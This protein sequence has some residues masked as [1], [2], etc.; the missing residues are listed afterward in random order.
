MKPKLEDVLNEKG[1]LVTTANGNSMQPFIR[2]N[3]D[4]V[5]LRKICDNTVLGIY[6]VILYKRENGSYVLHRILGKDPRGYILCGD[7]QTCKEYCIQREQILAVLEGVYRGKWYID[8][9]K[10]FYK[11]YVYLW[12]S[13]YGMIFRK[14]C[15]KTFMLLKKIQR[16]N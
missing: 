3:C 2:P 5:I 13:K 11:V 6:E 16:P 15:I 1:I 7:S 12:C 8:T 9:N 14:I 4:T 10:W